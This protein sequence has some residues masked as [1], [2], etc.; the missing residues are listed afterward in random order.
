MAWLGTDNGDNDMQ[1]SWYS[2]FSS[3]DREIVADEDCSGLFWPRQAYY[4]S[5][6]SSTHGSRMASPNPCASSDVLLTWNLDISAF[7]PPN[8]CTISL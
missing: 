8:S 5:Q 1:S 3:S 4:L 7:W 2:F 6:K